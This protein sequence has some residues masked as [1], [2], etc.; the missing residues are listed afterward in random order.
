[1]FGLG[2]TLTFIICILGWLKSYLRVV[3]L[4][5]GFDWKIYGEKEETS[6]FWQI[7][8][9]TSMRRSARLSV[10]LRLGVGTPRRTRGLSF[11]NF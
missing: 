11:Q 7:R 4:C 6:H 2:K 9:S 5:L 3:L 1:M 8:C 10:G